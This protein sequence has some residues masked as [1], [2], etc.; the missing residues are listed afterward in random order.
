[1]FFGIAA[2]LLSAL[3]ISIS[4]VF[5]RAHIEK[6]GDPVLLAVHSQ[7][8]MG[9]G[10]VLMLAVSFLFQGMPL[11]D[12]RFLLLLAGDVGFFLI[13]QTSFFIV[14]QQVEASR[15]SS[16]LG[17]KLIVLAAIACVIGRPLLGLQWLAIVLCTAAAVGM[18]FSGGHLSLKSAAWLMNS[19]LFYALCDSCIA[20]MM[21]MMPGRS[22][23]TNSFGVMGISDTVLALAV[24]PMLRKYPLRRETVRDAVPYGFFYFTSILF[25]MTCFGLI[26]VVFGSVIQAGRGIISVLLGVL[27]DR[28]GIGRTEPPVPRTVWLRR[29]LMAVLMLTAMALYTCASLGR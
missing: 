17:L 28:L 5:S 4:Y 9:A 12:G 3:L 8:V 25:L 16:L 7:L 11:G 27:L 14:I 24:L 13:G 23:L 2:G 1:M 20:E 21:L 26:G 18:N 29:A 15:A 22:M 10:G 6:H 19:V